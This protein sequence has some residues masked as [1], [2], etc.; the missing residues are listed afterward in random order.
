MAHRGPAAVEIVLSQDER[1][2]LARRAGLSDRRMAERARIILA[3][4][5]GM[6]NAGA[7][8]TVGASVKT[9]RKWCENFSTGGRQRLSASTSR[10][11]RRAAR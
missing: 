2:E 5:D 8:R 9:V 1:V 10:P 6:S 3:C 4:A 7:A 11:P